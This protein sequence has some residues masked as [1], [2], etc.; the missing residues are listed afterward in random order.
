MK[1]KILIG[2]PIKLNISNR[3]LT[4]FIQVFRN[5]RPDIII[6]VCCLDGTSVNFARNDICHYAKKI[7]AREIVWVDEDMGWDLEAWNR[8]IS[9]EDIDIVGH[10]YCKKLPGTPKWNVN[11]MAGK[12]IDP[13]TGL[14]EVEEIGCGFMKIR[15]DTVLA[16]MDLEYPENEYYVKTHTEG[17][18]PEGERGTAFEYFPMGVMGP[19][20][21][22]ARLERV[23]M[24]LERGFDQGELEGQQLRPPLDV[25]EEIYR[26]CYDEQLPGNLF[27]E[28][29]GFCRR[30]RAIGFKVYADFGAP[31]IGHIGPISFPITPE[32]VGL[33]PAASL[34]QKD[35]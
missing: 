34:A 26:A 27:G 18:P 30:A 9:F 2:V 31:P 22:G 21:H 35:P 20:S 17:L 15:V 25:L 19:R 16:K 29:Y 8:I 4:G 10:L 6:D 11:L 13:V 1:R 23:K 24:A 12:E 14:C 5:L 7:K 28:D 3:W 33:D 32:M